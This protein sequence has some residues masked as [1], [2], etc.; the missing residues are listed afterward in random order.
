MA[1]PLILCNPQEYVLGPQVEYLKQTA[2]QLGPHKIFKMNLKIKQS[3]LGAIKMKT[4]KSIAS[5]ISGIAGLGM[6]G[7]AHGAP[8]SYSS[9]SLGKSVSIIDM[10]DRGDII[11]RQGD[12][13]F[14]WSFDSSGQLIKVLLPFNQTDVYDINNLGEVLTRGGLYNTADKTL[15]RYNGII[16]GGFGFVNDNREIVLSNAIGYLPNSSANVIKLSNGKVN[17]AAFNNNGLAVD[18]DARVWDVHTG[19][20]IKTFSS[21]LNGG[22]TAFDLNEQN[23]ILFSNLSPSVKNSYLYGID[24]GQIQL[25]FLGYDLDNAGNVVGSINGVNGSNAVIWRSEANAVFDLNSY[26]SVGS[27]LVNATHINDKGWIVAQDNVGVSYLLKP[28][29]LPASGILFLSSLFGFLALQRKRLKIYLKP[30]FG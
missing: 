6:Q 17:A 24:G 14:H 22:Y 8:V 3:K 16:S 12:K 4:I 20:V 15:S 1:A 21:E 11:G 25:G 5:I 27:Q 26:L 29:P 2:R 18:A 9:E 10:N 23:H 19:K 13:L 30:L 28:V 7:A